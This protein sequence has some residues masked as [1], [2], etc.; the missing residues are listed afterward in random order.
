MKAVSKSLGEFIADVLSTVSAA[1]YLPAALVVGVGTVIGRFRV[2][3][4]LSPFE[5]LR[6]SGTPTWTEIA[7]FV[8]M[9]GI[10]ASVID[11][12]QFFVTRLLEGHIGGSGYRLQSNR[13]KFRELH[14]QRNGL[15]KSLAELKPDSAQAPEIK[16]KIVA[17]S[18]SLLKFPSRESRVTSSSLGNLIR[19]YEDRANTV[20]QKSA[21]LPKEI[22]PTIQD[23]LPA[24][25]FAV[26]SETRAQHD[27][28]RSQLTMLCTMVFVIPF[29]TFAAVISVL[30]HPM[31]AITFAIAGAIVTALS[32]SGAKAAGDGYGTMLLAIARQVGVGRV[33]MNTAVNSSSAPQV[34]SS[35]S[36]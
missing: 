20:L 17:I 16:D 35:E 26:P 36:A 27:Q 1:T 18:R 29:V 10:L 24:L 5:A 15:A 6:A 32:Y 22:P 21:A 30:E 11:P 31:W 12:L 14:D 7:V 8:V 13:R 19:A 23:V 33:T 9:T 4:K 34:A 2:D 3:T 25:Y 28:F